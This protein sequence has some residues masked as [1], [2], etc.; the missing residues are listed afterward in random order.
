MAQISQEMF[1][2]AVSE[3]SKAAFA[4]LLEQQAAE[5]E[6]VVEDEGEEA[7]AP[8]SE[9]AAYWKAIA[10]HHAGE[11]F[12]EEEAMQY[13][14]KL[15][16]GSYR[17]MPPVDQ[18]ETV[19]TGTSLTQPQ[20]KVTNRKNGITGTGSDGKPAQFIQLGAN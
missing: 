9:D 5:E 13:V 16:D 20:R 18:K 1:D 6:E 7:A 11:D 14:G 19:Q 15:P 3:A 12:N 2:A 8:L 17:Y 4:K 10:L